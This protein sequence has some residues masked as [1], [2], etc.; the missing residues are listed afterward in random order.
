MFQWD[1]ALASHITT[2][3]TSCRGG[4]ETTGL[5]SNLDWD[6]RPSLSWANARLTKPPLLHI[7]YTPFEADHVKNFHICGPSLPIIWSLSV[8]DVYALIPSLLTWSS[9]RPLLWLCCHHFINDYV[10]PLV[11]LL[12]L[13]RL[14]SF[15][16]L[17]GSLLEAG[18]I[19]LPLT[20]LSPKTTRAKW[21][22][23][24]FETK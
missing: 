17:H 8:D 7:G 21:V 1:M 22:F 4:F 24:E 11:F 14:F 5:T 23:W 12:L 6:L 18:T 15:S 13:G 9:S 19:S 2:F 3:Q 10:E 16:I 20:T